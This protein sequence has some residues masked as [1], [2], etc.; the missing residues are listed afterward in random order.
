MNAAAFSSSGLPLA[1]PF[2]AGEAR[3]LTSS[4]YVLGSTAAAPNASEQ[5][6]Q[7]A[8]SSLNLEN[9]MVPSAAIL[10]QR[11]AWRRSRLVQRRN[12]ELDGASAIL[13]RV[14][15]GL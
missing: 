8:G 4:R 14:L 12:I 5:T 2:N 3:Y 11:R 6:K 13:A 9:F 15:S 10:F 7:T 1:R